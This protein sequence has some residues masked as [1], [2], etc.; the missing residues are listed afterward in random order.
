MLA[1]TQTLQKLRIGSIT[2]AASATGMFFQGRI[3]SFAFKSFAGAK[4]ALEKIVRLSEWA[5]RWVN[6]W[7]QQSPTK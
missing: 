7:I 5:E 4:C 3:V 6:D 1:I 2:A